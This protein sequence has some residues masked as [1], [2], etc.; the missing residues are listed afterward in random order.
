MT[1]AARADHSPMQTVYAIRAGGLTGTLSEWTASPSKSRVEMVLGPLHQ[2][3]GD[4]GTTYW[5]Q[6]ASGHVRVVRGAERAEKRAA[7]SFSIDGYDPLK[8]GKAGRVTLRP[9]RAPGTGDYVLDVLPTGGPPQI[10]YLNPHTFLVDKLV[11]RSGGIAGT[12][13]IKAYRVVDG[14]QV[15][16]HLSI[17]YAGLPVTVDAQMVQARHIAQA[18]AALFA[19]PPS[20]RDYGFL[21]ASGAGPVTVP[22]DAAGNE[23]VVPVLVNGQARRFLLDSGAGTTFLTGQAAQN[24]GLTM[25]G[26]IAAL[27]Y[28][29]AT[30]AG[31]ATKA[32]IEI[33][34][35]VWMSGQSISV[36]SDP[37]LAK[38]LAAHGG[39]DGG[40]GYDLLTRFAV[41]IDYARKTLTFRAP[42][43]PS[44][45]AP[46][47]TVLPL[48]LANRV[49]TALARLDGKS[50]GRFLID[51]GDSGFLR[52]YAAFAQVAGL[53]SPSARAHS[54]YGEGI[55]GRVSETVSP[56]HALA[57]GH[58]T[59]RG[60]PVSAS[61]EPGISR[62]SL[63]A[64]GIGN[65]ILRQF[66][67][68]FDYPNERI[69]LAKASATTSPL[70]EG[71]EEVAA[72]VKAP[73]LATGLYV[74]DAATRVVLAKHL[75][76]L[77]GAQAVSAVTSIRVTQIVETGGI[78]GT[79]ITVYAAPNKEYDHSE[80]GGVLD[81]AEGFDG[82]TAWRRDTN[83]NVRL[84]GDD[85]T[86]ELKLQ[87]YIDTNSYVLP[88]FGIPGTITLRPQREPGTSDYI[89]DAVPQGGKPSTLFLD[90]HT[91]LIAKEQHLDDNVPVITTFSD[92]RAVDG[93]EYPYRQ[94]TS[95]GMARYDITAQVARIE[96][97]VVVPNSL[98][99]PPRGTGAKAEFIAPGRATATVPFDID[100]GEISL[101]VRINGTACRVFLDSGASGLA[102]SGDMAKRLHLKGEGVL[103]ARGYGGSTDLHPVHIDTFDIPGAVRLSGLAAVSL[104][105][106]SGFE[107]SLG[108]PLAGFIGYDL[109]SRF[110]VRID[111]ARRL[112]TLTAPEAFTPSPADG[113]PVALN[114]DND[115]PS[116]TAQFGTLPPASFLLDTGDVSGLRLYGPYVA[117]N[118]LSAKYPK[119]IPS[120]GGGI[121][122]ESRSALT[123]TPSLTVAGVTLRDLPTE[124]SLDTKGGASLVLA[125]SLGSQV[126]SR[127]VV[128]FDYPRRRVFFA[129]N[130]NATQPFDTRT[131]GIAVAQLTDP[132]GK[133]RLVVAD[134]APGS[135]AARAG[136]AVFDQLLA[137]DGQPAASLGLAEVR[138]RLSPVGGTPSHTLD[139]LSTDRVQRTVTVSL[140]DPLS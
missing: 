68:T 33:P 73:T 128:T 95:N 22:F 70:P 61:T 4:D 79:V 140:Y 138:R 29:K 126:L 117:Q 107:Y 17:G 115:I 77:G 75:A 13:T 14:E 9:A 81:T 35:G 64:G 99:T 25:Q 93:V 113:S 98:F 43:T 51:T 10:I 82:T 88:Q 132:Q 50:A 71:K 89:L 69:V 114:L 23:I 76:A 112:L 130:A 40:F 6:D 7:Q 103:E 102:L 97:N 27:G 16:S 18:D 60:V 20:A 53:A 8:P 46:N 131:F 121:G 65:G 36:L 41:T 44:P 80:L 47:A 21:T 26:H 49:P 94:R 72:S 45:L 83:G 127:F 86:R 101:P 62:V 133:T 106:P 48:S 38:T 67:V 135:P 129:P 12:I 5:Q 57:L 3:E 120:A 123:R 55:G 105:L 96:N 109:L 28:G 19:V 74:P 42:E 32:R 31:I 2:T 59:V 92:Y 137:I 104:A 24:I 110:V 122:G 84:L 34:G 111:Y 90:P 119:Q 15:P 100:S 37:H 11:S 134:V 136:V 125:G 118:N 58:E 108:D 56:G 139:L 78:K 91:F 116:I 1:G 124:F 87:L 85:E 30:S 63:L 39:V 52:V 54:Q 66:L